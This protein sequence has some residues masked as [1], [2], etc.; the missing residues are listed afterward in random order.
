MTN[1]ETNEL[2]F[3][4]HDHKIIENDKAQVYKITFF[5]K[6]VESGKITTKPKTEETVVEGGLKKQ[7]EREADYD[8]LPEEVMEAL[9]NSLSGTVK[10]VAQV[11]KAEEKDETNYFINDY[12]LD[13]LETRTFVDAGGEE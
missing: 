11:T 8:E 3:E 2:E 1:Y 10:A 5:T 13:S 12:N 4:I 9:K 7:R 6:D